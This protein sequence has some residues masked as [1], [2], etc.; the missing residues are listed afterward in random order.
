MDAITFWIY[1]LPIILNVILLIWWRY[2]C[3]WDYSTWKFPTRGHIVIT[4]LVS[5]IPIIGLLLTLFLYIFY[6]MNR[7]DHYLYLKKNKFNKF[8]FD[9]DDD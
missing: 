8:W 5:L 9:V 6:I 2:N 4:F 1:V 3:E 7:S